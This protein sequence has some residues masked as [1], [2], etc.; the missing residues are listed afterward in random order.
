MI[1]ASLDILLSGGK[2]VLAS[3]SPSVGLLANILQNTVNVL[4]FGI[5]IEES[6]VRPRFGGN[7][8]ERPGSIMVEVDVDA[9]IRQD[10]AGRGLNLHVVNP[11]NWH[12][13]SFEGIHITPDGYRACGD[14]R[15]NAMAIGV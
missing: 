5:P 11:W 6:V 1:Q 2:P 14:P 4:D 12:H 10:V 15:R 8:Y 7:S 3:G 13:G 9:K